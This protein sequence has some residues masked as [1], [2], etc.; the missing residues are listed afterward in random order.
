[1]LHAMGLPFAILGT[2]L[3]VYSWILIVRVLCTWFPTIDWYSEPYRTLARISDPYLNA[4]RFIPPIGMI[5]I[6][7]MVGIGILVWFVIPACGQMAHV[8]G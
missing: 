8:L 1:M 6:S 5:D 2:V 7:A 4:F 3:N